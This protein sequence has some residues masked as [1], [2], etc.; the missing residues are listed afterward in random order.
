[1]QAFDVEQLILSEE[2]W[3]IVSGAYRMASRKPASAHVHWTQ[4]LWNGLLHS[5][6]KRPEA[7]APDT[8]REFVA[9]TR[10]LRQPAYDLWPALNTR[11][12]TDIQ[13]AGIAALALG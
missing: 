2:D 5:G 12:F 6:E 13:I 8:L 7:T 4:R 3:D 11:G 9:M 10:Y 1:M